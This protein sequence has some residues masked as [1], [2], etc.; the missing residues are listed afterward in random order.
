MLLPN[1]GHFESSK[2][3]NVTFSRT[4]R[5]VLFFGVVYCASLPN[6]GPQISQSKK[7]WMTSN[8][9]ESGTVSGSCFIS[10]FSST[11]LTDLA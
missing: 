5:I 6:I 8:F 4:R 2:I 3:L 1:I 9:R 7:P 11:I 10:T